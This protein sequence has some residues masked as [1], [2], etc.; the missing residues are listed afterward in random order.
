MYFLTSE[1]S[2]ECSLVACD[3]KISQNFGRILKID[4]QK[5]R[6]RV[7]GSAVATSISIPRSAICGGGR[8]PRSTVD[9]GRRRRSA[10]GRDR[11]RPKAGVGACRASR[12]RTRTEAPIQVRKGPFD[13]P[14]CVSPL[15]Q[16]EPGKKRQ[17]FSSLRVRSTE[18]SPKCDSGCF[19][20]VYP[21]KAE[22]R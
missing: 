16:A 11:R 13:P 9:G 22:P 4:S 20:A 10:K 15:V 18:K 19:F 7:H 12:A 6:V 21:A 2:C 1:G 3:V 5:S 14:L 17:I 8:R